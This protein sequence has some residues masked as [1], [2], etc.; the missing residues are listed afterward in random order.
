MKTIGFVISGKP[1]EKRRAILPE[2]VKMVSNSSMIMIERGYGRV[3]GIDDS[4]YAQSGARIVSTEDVYAADIVC[5]P[6]T[7]TSDEASR[8]NK[9]QTLFGWIHAV[10]GREIV[11]FLVAREMTAVAWE[12][13]YYTDSRHVFWR[14][15]EIAG[16][17][18]IVHALPFLSIVPSELVVAVIGRGNTA[19]GAT[20]I[21]DRLGARVDIYDRR[22]VHS[23]RDR[24]YA[25]DIVVNAVMWDVFEEKRLIYRDDLARMK[26]G[27][28]IVDISCDEG[29]EIETSRPTTIDN[30]VY[31]VDGV[32][33]YAVD[34]TPTIFHRSATESISAAI[35][36]FLDDLIC[37][38]ENHILKAATPILGGRI[39]DERILRY[40]SRCSVG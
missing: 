33:H 5:N 1:N 22:R 9:G 24:L 13:M 37:E 14:N 15:N 29:L 6:K 35:A 25:Y 31:E 28:M 39:L 3:L 16:E 10:Q 19:R 32:L 18:A 34:H 4:Q 7:P 23:L 21:L 12:D 8:F 38:K 17:A 11:D 40:Q 2:N 27:S 36:P 20:R 30:P 26:E